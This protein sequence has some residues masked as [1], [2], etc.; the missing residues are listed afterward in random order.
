VSCFSAETMVG[1]NVGGPKNRWESPNTRT[2]RFNV[3]FAKDRETKNLQK[4][5]LASKVVNPFT[6]AHAPPFIGRRR[7]FLHPENTLESKEYS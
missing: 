5:A 3:R 7:D 6:C 4:T 1:A 2:M